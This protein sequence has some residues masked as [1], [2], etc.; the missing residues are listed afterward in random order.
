MGLSPESL[1]N[2]AL[3]FLYHLDPCV[4]SWISWSNVLSRALEVTPGSKSWPETKMT[5]PS[6]AGFSWA[7]SLKALFFNLFIQ[8]PVGVCNF[9]Q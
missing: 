7:R 8:F 6:L 5:G 9:N 4:A 2:M 3:N 1:P